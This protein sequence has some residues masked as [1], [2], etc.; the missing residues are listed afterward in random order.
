MAILKG[1]GAAGNYWQKV[2]WHKYTPA[3][4]NNT[5]QKIDAYTDMGFLWCW[6]EEQK[7]KEEVMYGTLNHTVEVKIH[8]RGYPD[9]SAK[10]EFTDRY[11]TRRLV[12]KGYLY[13]W[14]AGEVVVE[15][16]QVPSRGA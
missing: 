14:N 13:D 16:Y 9:V 7:P 8:L 4:D 15:A 10:D 1:S 5:G 2:T 3:V 6:N 11:T 12:T